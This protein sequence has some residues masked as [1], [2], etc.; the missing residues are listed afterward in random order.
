M[1]RAIVSM[2]LVACL[3]LP[4]HAQT[5]QISVAEAKNQA[6]EISTRFNECWNKRDPDGITSLF[7]S[8]AVVALPSGK[9]LKGTDEVKQFYAS[10]LG[11]RD[12]NLTHD[13]VVD[14]VRVSG[15]AGVWAIGHTTITAEGKV[16]SKGHWA[17]AYRVENGRMLV[18]MLSAGTDAT[19]PPPSTT[20]QK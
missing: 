9:V 15:P 2:M 3:S 10:F 6:G 18:E 11:G 1:R 16:V 19:P 14:E 7:A 8:D 13:A 4:A 12:K 5:K 20:V 17:A